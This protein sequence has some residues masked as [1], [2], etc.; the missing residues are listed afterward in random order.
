MSP[1]KVICPVCSNFVNIKKFGNGWLGLCCREIVY[2]SVQLP[3]TKLTENV[4]TS[5]NIISKQF[6]L[7][8][9]QTTKQRTY[10]KSVLINLA[11]GGR[12]AVITSQ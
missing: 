5:I 7:N 8:P 3:R 4:K 6:F 11:S 10:M 9:L 2:N 12:H 1:A